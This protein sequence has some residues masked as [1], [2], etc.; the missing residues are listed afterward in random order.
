LLKTVQK[1]IQLQLSITQNISKEPSWRTNIISRSVIMESLLQQTNQVAQS[2]FS[3]LIHSA[4][5]TGKELLA[6]NQ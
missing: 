4:C 5:G 1:A 6:N 3:L 2:D